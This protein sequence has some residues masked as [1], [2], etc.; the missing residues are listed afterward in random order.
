MLFGIRYNLCKLYDI[1]E[2]FYVRNKILYGV[3]NVLFI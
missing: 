1:M 2:L 3:E